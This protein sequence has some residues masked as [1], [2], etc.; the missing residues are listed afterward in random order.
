MAAEI[1]GI[2]KI[3]KY[4]AKFDFQK[5]KLTRGTET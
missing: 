2:D 4:I 1:V 5:I 3:N